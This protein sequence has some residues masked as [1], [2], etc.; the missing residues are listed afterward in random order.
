[1]AVQLLVEY[2]MA[3]IDEHAIC[4]GL[5]CVQLSGRFQILPGP[6]QRI[7][8]VTHNQQGAENLAAVLDETPCQGKTLAVIAMLRD[9]D[10]AAVFKALGQQVAHWYLGGL[11]GNRGQPAESLALSLQAAVTDAGY[12]TSETV[13]QAYH[14]A[15]QSAGPGDRIL[16]FGS[17]HT[18]E[19]VM[20]QIPA[21]LPA[22]LAVSA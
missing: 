13:E 16:I 11:N 1:M 6:V 20:R 5:K 17:F 12:S 21:L 15:M 2:G 14:L 22:D 10:S 7:F 3:E 4:R 9:K 8:D 18:V 19:A